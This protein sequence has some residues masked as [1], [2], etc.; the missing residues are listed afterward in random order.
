MFGVIGFKV[1]I[2]VRTFTSFVS[3]LSRHMLTVKI[4]IPLPWPVQFCGDES[5][6]YKVVISACDNGQSQSSVLKIKTTQRGLNVS[7]SG[8]A[9]SKLWG[10]KFRQQGSFLNARDIEPVLM[11]CWSTVVDGGQTLHRLW[12]IFSFLRCL[13]ICR[14]EPDQAGSCRGRSFFPLSGWETGW[15]KAA[16]R[17]SPI[18]FQ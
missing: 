12:D 4:M 5:K 18:L 15:N 9:L 14:K 6:R 3:P 11:Q 13:Y 1:F 8:P 10:K 17:R 7:Y 16:R 2:F